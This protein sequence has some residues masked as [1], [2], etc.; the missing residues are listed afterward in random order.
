MAVITNVDAHFRIARVEHGISEV[1]GTEVVLLPEA[2]RGMRN[3]VL[4][5]FAEVGAVGV[6]DGGGVVVDART[7]LFIKR[8]DDDHAVF[9]RVLLHQLRRRTVGDALDGV[10]PSRIL[11]SAK[12]GTGEDFLHAEDL[13]AF[14]SG[15]ID[16][17]QRALDL[18]IANGLD[19]LVGTG[20][21]RR[22]NQTALHDSGH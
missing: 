6:D 12:I 18:R 15:L 13:H 1:A 21:E 22:L 11:F 14:L 16:E 9:L 3:V 8:D 4:A 10:I 17:F 2:R 19:L 5:I 20:R 7:F